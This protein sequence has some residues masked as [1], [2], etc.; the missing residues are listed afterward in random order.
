[1]ALA[2]G[3]LD[4]VDG[5]EG[6]DDADAA[7][8]AWAAP[9]GLGGGRWTEQEAFNA[10]LAASVHAATATTAAYHADVAVQH[11]V[12]LAHQV[13]YL[14]MT[15]YALRAKVGELEQW[16][17]SALEDVRKLR[18]EHKALWQRLLSEERSEDL[19]PAKSMSATQLAFQPSPRV[20]AQEVDAPFVSFGSFPHRPSS[21]SMFGLDSDVD[22]GTLE[23]ITVVDGQVDGAL[24]LRAEWRIGNLSSK[25][26][27]CKGRALV[28]SPF[29]CAGLEDLRLM[30][31]PD[32]TD[33]AGN[34]RRTRAQK[35]LYMKKVT[36]GPLDACLR[37]KAPSSSSSS[38][39]HEI[40]YYLKVGSKRMGPFKHNF[41]ESTVSGCDSFGVDWLTKLEADLSLV[42]CVEIL[43]PPGGFGT[44]SRAC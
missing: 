25:L 8:A 5:A 29:R 22:G 21:S 13:Q 38:G 10:E 20:A 37:L 14:Q 31:C 36:E 43:A 3:M 28:S 1:M 7:W 15:V 30:V 17:T 39:P 9:P 27:G 19:L 44:S 4:D 35:E 34:H 26:R 33:A 16:R 23:G 32:G 42:V 40:N 2:L 11:A 41:T 6:E 12:R 18:E 24:C